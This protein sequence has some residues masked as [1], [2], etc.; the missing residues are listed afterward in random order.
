MAEGIDQ[1]RH[2]FGLMTDLQRFV[3]NLKNMFQ[4]CSNF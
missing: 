2:I 3:N 1:K 4:L